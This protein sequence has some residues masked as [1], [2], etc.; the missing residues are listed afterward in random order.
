MALANTGTLQTN[1]NV[2]P[3]YDDYDE[4]KNFHRVLFKPGLAVQARELTQLQTIL[5]NQID[6]F[7]EHIFKEGSVVRGNA[8]ST[9]DQ[10]VAV[11]IL[12]EQASVS[13][14]VDNF[15]G[16]E[17]TGGTNGLKGI[18]VDVADGVE[19]SLPDTKTLFV[20][21]LNAG[22][23]GV[24]RFYDDNE[25]ITSNTGVTA[26]TLSANSSGYGYQVTINEGIIFAKDHFIRADKQTAIVSKYSQTP[27][28]R[29][30]YLIDEEIV[31]FTDDNTLLDPAQGAY[32]YAA[33]GAD[34]LKLTPTLTVLDITDTIPDNF[35][36]RVVIEDG[37]VKE[38]YDKTVYN[39]IRDYMAQRTYDESGDY[40]V[41]G[42]NV[43]LNEHLQGTGNRGIYNSTDQGG[44]TALLAAGISPGKGYVRG[45]DFELLKSIY[46]N[47]EK[48]IDTNILTGTTQYSNI[49]NYVLVN[50]L[51]GAWDYDEHA[52]VQL[53]SSPAQAVTLADTKSVPS[54]Q[55][56]TAKIR[57]LEWESGVKGSADGQYRM[58]LYD[59]TMTANSFAHVR[60]IY[61]STTTPDSYADIVLQD[62][63]LGSSNTAALENTSLNSFIINLPAENLITDTTAYLGSDSDALSSVSYETKKFLT[64]TWDSL[65]NPG[66]VK[67]LQALT[68]PFVHVDVV[69]ALSSTGAREKWQ[70]TATTDFTAK[71]P[72]ATNVTRV[73]GSN[74]FTFS[75]PPSAFMNI[76]EYFVIDGEAGANNYLVDSFD[77]NDVITSGPSKDNGDSGTLTIR[78]SFLQGQVIPI[79][80]ATGYAVGGNV[81]VGG[82][83]RSITIDSTTT[84]TINLVDIPVS[85]QTLTV[86]AVVKNGS[87]PN[88][89]TSAT[90]TLVPNQYVL[91]D[92][93][94]SGVV[95]PFSLGVPDAFKLKGVFKKSSFADV[96]ESSSAEDVTNQFELITNQNDNYYG[97][98]KVRLKNSATISLTASDDLLFKFDHFTRSGS[99]YLS[100]DSY[101]IDDSLF[102]DSDTSI[103]SEELP[104]YIN[105][106]GERVQ[107]RDVIDFRPYVT[108]IAQSPVSSGAPNTIPAAPSDTSTTIS[109]TGLNSIHPDR[110]FNA[111]IQFN[112]P[113][114]DLLIIN[115]N[116]F[117]SIIQGISSLNPITP[118]HN[119][120]DGLLL[121]TIDIPAYPSMSP[122][123]ATSLGK[124]SDGAK[125]KQNRQVRFTMKDIGTLKQRIENVEYY[126]SLNLLEKSITDLEIGDVNGLNRFKNGFFVDP[127][128]GHSYADVT[129]PD[130]T[131][132]IDKVANE[133]TPA[134]RNLDIP[135]D[136]VLST[137]T[138]QKG[139]F[140]LIDY[141]EVL[142]IDQPFASTAADLSALNFQYN[143]VLT[144][145]PPSDY[146]QETKIAPD[147]NVTLDSGI[148]DALQ[149]SLDG[150]KQIG[151]GTE[152]TNSG[153][154]TSRRGQK[155]SVKQSNTYQETIVDGEVTTGVSAAQSLGDFVIDTSL[156]P[157]MRS[158]EVKFKAVGM[159]P[160]ARLA[161][162][163]DG[164][165]V[166]QDCQ[167]TDINYN[168]LGTQPFDPNPG[169]KV[170]E[171]DDDIAAGYNKGEVYGIFT[172]PAGRFHTGSLTFVLTDNPVSTTEPDNTTYAS[173][174]FSSQGLSTITQGTS[175]STVTADLDLDVYNRTYRSTSTDS[176]T[177][178]NPPQN[179]YNITNLTN[180]TYN[181]F[182]SDPSGTDDFSDPSCGE[183]DDGDNCG[184]R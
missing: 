105:S 68:N 92:L 150:M 108:A 101:P 21:Y 109:G 106:L 36:E 121:A 119:D 110:I 114:K 156:I 77:G 30:G 170:A 118:R 135:L 32:N 46:V 72:L 12:D 102:S 47:V 75:T 98:S 28:V 157:F 29:V 111:D 54:T 136:L 93:S 48:G 66:E 25:M 11:R 141:D 88:Y 133:I 15:K 155:V 120:N 146:F 130:H 172:I 2:D 103:R 81:A 35:I 138:K 165:A 69:G 16:T 94:T 18:V 50:E 96:S 79:A 178:P 3:Y 55:I 56:G 180:N 99:S 158:I 53:H 137:Q 4:S 83:D 169:L 160:G 85:D 45:Y 5:Q 182:D 60:S 43:I 17:I 159:R 131:A 153:I 23:S 89:A 176:Y 51:I 113:R 42:L 179:I 126:T 19:A 167:Q 128:R 74:T 122:F 37:F 151:S 132:A 10:I 181:S 124:S 59:V 34:R 152:L 76:G 134:E 38:R 104:V 39:I 1:F 184:F 44:N 73:A 57:G 78:K 20:K 33:P 49:G 175:V 161:A 174:K 90:K 115:R 107:L 80:D 144:L 61:T 162:Y 58:Y 177:I 147:R 139:D 9:D 183:P 7:G 97:T 41:E 31:S 87:D 70:V 82:T 154:S 65:T 142:M 140:L 24:T 164:F 26:T 95:G 27:N 171:D 6:R 86:T 64:G 13:V 148:G 52:V 129:N 168:I 166:T 71:H 91:H 127:L 8:V 145:D 143:G 116:G 117:P 163:F 84:A 123:Y 149:S 14:D 63:S 67:S 22:T 62:G 173:A 125:L 40:I 100:V 112:L